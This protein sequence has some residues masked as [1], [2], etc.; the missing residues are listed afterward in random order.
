MTFFV[1]SDLPNHFGLAPPLPATISVEIIGKQLKI[2]IAENIE[3]LMI[4]R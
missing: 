4:E 3:N 2:L 1:D